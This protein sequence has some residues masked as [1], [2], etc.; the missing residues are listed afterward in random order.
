MT[1]YTITY[2]LKTEY[3][4]EDANRINMITLD[5]V[6]ESEIKAIDMSREI[7]GDKFILESVEE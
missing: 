6:A 2:S 7:V 1:L 4:N 3:Y 5:V